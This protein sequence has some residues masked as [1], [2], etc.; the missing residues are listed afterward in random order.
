MEQKPFPLSLA[1]AP[2][3]WYIVI[4]LENGERNRLLKPGGRDDD[5]DETIPYLFHTQQ[6]AWEFIK[7]LFSFCLK[8]ARM[9]CLHTDKII[10]CIQCGRVFRAKFFDCC[11]SCM[12]DNEFMLQQIWQGFYYLTGSE[13]STMRKISLL[14]KLSEEDFSLM[15]EAFKTIVQRQLTIFSDE[16]DKRKSPDQQLAKLVKARVSGLHVSKRRH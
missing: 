8:Q 14:L 6:E 12:K 2:G 16:S 4:L 15:P 13:A 9:Q 3:G 7:E 11:T 1:P 5:D 10:N